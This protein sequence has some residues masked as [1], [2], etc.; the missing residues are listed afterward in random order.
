M[1]EPFY[2]RGAPPF[3]FG[4]IARHGR[5]KFLL[6]VGVDPLNLGSHEGKAYL[7]QLSA[8]DAAT[9]QKFPPPYPFGSIGRR[10]P[11]HWTNPGAMRTIY[12]VCTGNAERST[13]NDDVPAAT[14]VPGK[15]RHG[16]NYSISVAN[17]V[18]PTA[19]P[20]ATVGFLDLDDLDG[21]L[22]YLLPMGLDGAELLVRRGDPEAPFSTFSTVARLTTAGIRGNTRRK[23]ILLRDLT[24]RLQNA[25]L[26]GQRYA[27]TGGVEGDPEITGQIKPL[28]F[29]PCFNVSPKLINA[30]KLIGQVT[31][32]SILA[33]DRVKDGGVPLD[34]AGD[35]P[36]FQSLFDASIGADQYATCLDLGLVRWGSK[37]VTVITVDFRGDNDALNG[38]AY[39]HTRAQIVRRIACGR[40]NI[41]LSDPADIDTQAF[42]A[43]EIWQPATLNYYF[44][45]EITKAEA[46][47]KV[48]AGCAGWWTIGLDGKL[49]AG[50]IE[51]PAN[52]VP[53]FELAFP[54]DDDNVDSRVDDPELTDW[55]PPR[56]TT[57]MGYQRNYT[58][59][60]EDQILG[61][62]AADSA[63][64]TSEAS[65]VTFEDAWVAGAF[66]SAAVV[67][68]DDS[69]FTFAD[70]A[71]REANRQG[72]VFRTRREPYDIPAVMDPFA[73]VVGKVARVTGANK[74]GL[75]T[76][77]NL[78]VYGVSNN[79]G[80]KAIIHG[81]G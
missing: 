18:Y 16:I 79:A 31:F 55:A 14:W 62:A 61:A 40:G 26:H 76:A 35:F 7:L 73:P 63:V 80:P 67:T 75:G 53:D 72:R 37:P 27:G 66:P 25:E 38:A 64:L 58:P 20:Q 19:A 15:L 42:E 41:R 6:Y 78:F 69:G 44:D 81:W 36:D 23:E 48:M 56:R 17:G 47:A 13:E 70:D 51:D 45:K 59:M 11:R 8:F 49:A 60:S 24:H 12:P 43:L 77:R 54:S 9:V 57:V 33:V 50:Q 1:T 65:F 32:T 28:G 71:R 52:A 5:G 34:P 4:S 30:Q 68:I 2:I 74:I 39:P 10:V 22:N 21:E 3:P 29:G 46:I